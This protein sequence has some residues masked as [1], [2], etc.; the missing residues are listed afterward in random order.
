MNWSQ[1]TEVLE[2]HIR[3]ETFPVAMRML[4]PGEEPPPRARRPW[5][6]LGVRMATCQVWNTARRYGWTLAASLEDLSC[7]PGKI[8]VGFEPAIA[9]YLEGHICA[10][11]YTES[12]EAGAR[13]EAATP[14]FDYQRYAMVVAAPL[15]RASFDPD[16]IVVYG[17]SAQIMRL[18]VAA[19][20][21]GGGRLE[22]SFT[23]RLDCSDILVHTSRKDSPQVILP[24]YGDRIF[25]QT[26][27]HEMAFAFT[28]AQLPALLEGL[29]GTHRGGVRY[30]IPNF[31]RYTAHYPEKYEHMEEIW[32]PDE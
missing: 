12:A 7:P 5:R 14:R 15:A 29:E 18:V 16:V 19:L 9:Y 23:G 13:T 28:P 20:Y 8:V 31:M 22:S 3:P 27:D 10:G 2:R 11:M 1:V 21:Q 6:D 26:Q 24:C 32:H 25:G 17:N 30:P 4:P